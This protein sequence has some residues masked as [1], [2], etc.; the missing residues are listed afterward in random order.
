MSDRES[1]EQSRQNEAAGPQ[2]AQAPIPPYAQPSAQPPVYPN[3]PDPH[4]DKPKGSVS[5]AVLAWSVVL[6]I[7]LTAC[8]TLGLVFALNFAKFAGGFVT[9]TPKT[10]TEATTEAGTGATVLTPG[11]L[12]NDTAATEISV[13]GISIRVAENADEETKAKAQKLAQAI[14]AFQR[15]FYR[16]LSSAE[17]LEAMTAGLPSNLG[18]PYSYYMTAEDLLPCKTPMPAITQ[19]SARKSCR[20][21]KVHSSLLT[22]RLQARLKPADS[23]QV[24]LLPLLTGRMREIFRTRPLWPIKLKAPRAPWWFSRFIAPPKAEVLKSN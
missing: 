4:A 14:D 8:F 21:C 17:L 11:G 7:V 3:Y 12:A 19:V 20:T 10:T 2:Y 5:I 9:T 1:Y 13:D 23:S 6:S 24:I 15:N 16:E 22:S 18:S